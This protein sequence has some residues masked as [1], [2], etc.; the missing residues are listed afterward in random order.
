MAFEEIEK[1]LQNPETSESWAHASAN[2][3]F[4]TEFFSIC[5]KPDIDSVLR[6]IRGL[7]RDALGC[8]DANVYFDL[9]ESGFLHKNE[10]NGLRFSP[11]RGISGHVF[12][13]GAALARAPFRSA[14]PEESADFDRDIDGCGIGFHVHSLLSCPAID[15]CGRVRGVIQGLNKVGA[16]HIFGPPDALVARAVAAQAAAAVAAVLDGQNNDDAARL[17]ALDA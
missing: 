9:R 7:V 15:P 11:S 2:L 8:E 13:E 17:R 6:K 10:W 1:A 3:L 5:L 14:A 12:R 4:N 16:A